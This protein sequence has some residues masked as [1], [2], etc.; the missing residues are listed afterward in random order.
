MCL[1]STAG[2]GMKHPSPGTGASC[3][4]GKE[5]ICSSISFLKTWMSLGGP[6]QWFVKCLPKARRKLICLLRWARISYFVGGISL[7]LCVMLRNSPFGADHSLFCFNR[8]TPIYSLNI[9]I[10]TA[11]VLKW[12]FCENL[13]RWVIM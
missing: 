12:D 9:G 4:A 6:R 13:E 11:R 7:F 8:R 10:R 3:P 1:H 2:A 5:T